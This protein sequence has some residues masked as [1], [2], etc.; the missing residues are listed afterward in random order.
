MEPGTVPENQAL[1]VET[2][3][4]AWIE[5]LLMNACGYA[6]VIIPGFLLVHYLKQSNYLEQHGMFNMEVFFVVE[7]IK[8]S[9]LILL[10]RPLQQSL[11][12]SFRFRL[13]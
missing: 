3:S 8:L 1:V 9:T 11:S 2:M 10:F 13:D 12:A 4:Y 6:S 5:S 7:L